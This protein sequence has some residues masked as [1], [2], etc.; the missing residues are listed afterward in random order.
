MMVVEGIKV[1]TGKLNDTK[2]V[3]LS[4][5][6]RVLCSQPLEPKNPKC[7]VCSKS[8]ITVKLNTKIMTLQEFRDDVLKAELGF[9]EP[10][11]N[12]LSP[13]QNFMEY[14]DQEDSYLKKTC[15]EVHIVGACEISVEDFSTSL[16]ATICVIDAELD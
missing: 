1:L 5:P 15:E 4:F 6:P 10:D 14:G 11:I 2:S 12:V 3:W 16:S 13:K 7:Y 8:R 9:T